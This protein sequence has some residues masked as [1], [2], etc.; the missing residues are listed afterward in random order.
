MS[1]NDNTQRNQNESSGNARREARS[2]RDDRSSR[3]DRGSRRPRRRGRRRRREDYFDS[4]NTEPNYKDVDTLRRFMSERAKIRPR[5]QTALTA[6]NQ[7]KLAREIKRARH[8]ALLP[9]T[10]EHQ[11]S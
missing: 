8:M 1:E 6:K 4:T 11:R 2:Q 7:R 5:R 3:E 9:F 10:D